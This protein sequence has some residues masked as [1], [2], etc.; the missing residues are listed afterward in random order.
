MSKTMIDKMIG[1]FLG[2]KLPH[3][4]GPDGY[5]TFDR[6]KAETNQQF[7]PVGTNLLTAAQA[8]QMIEH[9]LVGVKLPDSQTDVKTMSEL[10][11][12]ELQQIA[13]ILDRRANEIA[14]FYDEYRRNGAHHGTVELALDRE[15]RRLR[16]LADR[17][18]PMIIEGAKE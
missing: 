10:A 5:I 4:F 18:A 11:E 2:W 15:I 7:W 12:S 14:V 13:E 6:E 1:N 8:R 3:D 17:A 16:R 9:M